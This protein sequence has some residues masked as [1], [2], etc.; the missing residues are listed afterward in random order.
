MTLRKE[1]AMI[2]INGQSK[3]MKQGDIVLGVELLK[4][5]RD[6]VQVCFEKEKKFVRK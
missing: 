1:L 4:I 5:Y 3:L 6:S 2:H